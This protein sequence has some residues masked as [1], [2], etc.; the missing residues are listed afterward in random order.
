M[1]LAVILYY[2]LKRKFNK[3]FIWEIETTDIGNG[4][5]KVELSKVYELRI[6][7]YSVTSHWFHTWA[8]VP[9][10]GFLFNPDSSPA[11][12]FLHSWLS[13][14]SCLLVFYGP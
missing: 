5:V 6:V 2:C 13:C 7:C 11:L 1:Y 8:L 9:H 10:I 14:G 3:L 4:Q 12:R